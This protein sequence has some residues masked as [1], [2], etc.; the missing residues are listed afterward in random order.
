MDQKCA[1]ISNGLVS[2]NLPLECLDFF[3]EIRRHTW[4]NM[5]ASPGEQRAM[6]QHVQFD[7]SMKPTM[8]AIKHNFIK[9]V[10][11]DIFMPRGY[12]FLQ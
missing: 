10:R 7:L 3:Y 9:T 12:M 11:A 5:R 1:S 2:S 6:L 8:C 4:Y